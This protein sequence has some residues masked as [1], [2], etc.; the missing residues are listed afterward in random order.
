M[1][2][3]E[4]ARQDS[5]AR[6][7]RF[8]GD[9]GRSDA[10]DS[11]ELAPRSDPTFSN[12][13]AD[14]HTVTLAPE[15]GSSNCSCSGDRVRKAVWKEGEATWLRSRGAAGACDARDM[16]A[17]PLP[18]RRAYDHR[19]R[20]QVCRGLT[21]GRRLQIPRSTVASW[22]RRRLRP[23][24]TTEEL[25]EDREALFDRVGKLE[26]RV[27]VLAV[28]VR[29][30]LALL[31]A[32][33][34]RLATVRLPEGSTKARMLRAIAG[35]QAVLPLSKALRLVGLS[36]SRYHAW[37]GAAEGCGLDDRTS[38]PRL[39][40]TQVSASEVA[41]IKEMVTGP[42]YRHM[43]LKTLALYAQRVG[44]VF[45]SVTTWTRLMVERG[46]RR[47]RQRVHP[48][49]PQVGVRATRPNELW[50]V[51]ATILKLLDGT[52]AYVHAVIDNYSRRILAW[53]IVPKLDPVTTCELLLAAGKHLDPT[54]TARPSVVAD[55]GAENVNSK[56]DETLA[57]TG[58]KR[59]LALVE[60]SY[61]NSMIEAWW[62]A[63]K[64]QWLYLNA[65]DSL[66]RLSDLV[67]FYV[68]AHNTQMPRSAFGGRTPD[69][70][71]FGTALNLAAE[72]K[73]AHLTAR[74][75]R[76]ADNRAVSFPRC[77]VP[78]I[79]P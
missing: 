7:S 6:T 33:G 1:R 78:P 54:A 52:K 79:P 64:H 51:D 58:L 18:Q 57:S 56:V 60:V 8:G 26:R 2:R 61:S 34:F 66:S 15:S 35:A 32:S 48:E 67:A 74:E 63:L 13:Q 9:A 14:C 59:I 17:A 50:H 24:V 10:N 70:V 23:V 68:E 29:L 12:A 55:S 42:E 22:K 46:W 41:A 77:S 11:T 69:E 36:P 38:C 73:A 43:P 16:T 31:R 65:L 20:E 62:K 45:A 47:P 76:R 44:K 37:K 27:L 28:V 4:R 49:R 21:P 40:P 72:L 19:L 39:H 30:L 3:E 25:H 53:T 71:F 5:N 75:K